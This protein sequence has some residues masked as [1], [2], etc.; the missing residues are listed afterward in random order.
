[1]LIIVKK[2]TRKHG[3]LAICLYLGK[4]LMMKS[5]F[6]LPQIDRN[7]HQ[8]YELNLMENYETI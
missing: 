2:E 7:F 8:N 3:N 1:M 6:I 4:S 5:I